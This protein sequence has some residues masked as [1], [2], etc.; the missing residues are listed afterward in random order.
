MEMSPQLARLVAW[1]EEMHARVMQAEQAAL[2]VMGDMPAYTA[3]MQEKARLL[4][5]LEEEGEAYLEEL[6]EQLQDQA[7]HRLHRFSASARNALRIGSIFYMSALLYPEDHKPGQPDDLQVFIRR[8]R[9]EA[10]TTPCTRRTSGRFFPGAG[11]LWGSRT[12]PFP[13]PIL[14]PA[15]LARKD[16]TPAAAL[17]PFPDA[18]LPVLPRRSPH[19]RF[20]EGRGK[21]ATFPLVKASRPRRPE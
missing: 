11:G 20:R 8:L 12:R 16:M 9:D 18:G 15:R 13:R 2:A 3:R 7:G 6:P 19:G 17:R 5:S 14:P 10:S 4:A 21:A 1:L